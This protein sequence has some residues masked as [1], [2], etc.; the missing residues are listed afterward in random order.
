MCIFVFAKKYYIYI[1]QRRKNEK[2]NINENVF[3]DNYLF[4]YSYSFFDSASFE[5]EQGR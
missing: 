3:I 1:I 2:K 5:W 4:D